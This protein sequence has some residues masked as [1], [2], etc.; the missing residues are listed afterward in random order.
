MCGIRRQQLGPGLCS[1][2][3]D[4]RREK[5]KQ[6]KQNKTAVVKV[7]SWGGEEDPSSFLDRRRKTVLGSV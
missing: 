3:F 6:K 1:A 4:S 7:S 2:D 5:I